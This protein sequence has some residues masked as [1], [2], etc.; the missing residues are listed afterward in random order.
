MEPIGSGRAAEVFRHGPDTV[1]RR[2]RDGRDCELEHRVMAWLHAEGVPVPRV[3]DD[4]PPGAIIMEHVAGPSM[5]ED[6]A[7]APHHA[8]AH[9]RTLARLQD[10]IAR[11]AAPEWFPVKGNEPGGSVVHLDLH[12]MNV[13]LGEHGPV[14]IDW[15]NAGRGAASLDAAMTYLLVSTFEVEGAV[16]RIAQRAFGGTFA[17]F[18]G[19]RTVAAGIADAAEI[20]LADPN[21]TPGERDAVERLRARHR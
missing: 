4:P 19:R 20:R 10:R 17:L 13:M 15:T 1:L 14:I 9:A 11:L 2:Y 12:P 8:L 21:T 7:A 18:R 16:E 5:F 3:H 6:L